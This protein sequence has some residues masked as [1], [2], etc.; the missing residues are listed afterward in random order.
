MGHYLIGGRLTPLMVVLVLTQWKVVG[1]DLYIV[2]HS[3]DFVVDRVQA[4]SLSTTSSTP[5]N[6]VPLM[7]ILCQQV[8][9]PGSD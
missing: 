3:L 6:W 5:A 4:T 2:D 7:V 8:T 1:S 9:H